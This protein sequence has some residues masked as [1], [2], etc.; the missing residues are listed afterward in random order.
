MFVRK[1]EAVPIEFEGLRIFDFTSDKALSSSF[2]MIEVPSGSEHAMARSKRSD[3][4]YLVVDGSINFTLECVEVDLVKGDFCFVM[5]GDK[6][7]YRKTVSAD[8]LLVLAHTP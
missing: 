8:A 1:S 3:K 5:Q 6:F 2:A 4:Y 7:G